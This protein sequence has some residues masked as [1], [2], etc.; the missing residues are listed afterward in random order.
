MGESVK[1]QTIK[2]VFW[3]VL[4]KMSTYLVTFVINVIMA[5]L[6]T[7]A[8]YGIVGI[9]AVFVSFSQLFIDGGFT[10]A[11]IAKSDRDETDYRTV[12]VFNFICSI[13]LYILLFL[14]APIIEQFYG[15]TQL[16]KI[17]RAYCVILV[18]SSLSAVQITQLTI[19]ID[20]KSISKIN[21][22]TGVISGCFGVYLAYSGF[23]V[24]AIV[25]QQLLNAALRVL[26]AIYYS[27]WY[28]IFTFSFQRFKKLF[29]FS[30]NLV[31][32]SLIDRIYTNSFPLFI[33]KFFAPAVLG[34]Y[35]RGVQFGSL[36]SNIMGDILNR[37][38]FP[39]MSNIQ[40]D[41]ASLV[42]LYRKYIKLSS[43]VIFPIMMI[44]VVAAEP[45][46]R[47]LLTDKW[48]GCV[49]FMQI[50]SMAFMLAHIGVINRNLLYV[51]KHS[52]WALRLEIVK[53]IV[54]ISIFLFSTLWGIWGVVVGQWFYDMIAPSL[55][56]YYTKRLI[57]LSLW[58]QIHDYIG[59]W[60]ISVLSAVIPLWMVTKIDNVVLQMTL[61]IISY[62]LIYVIVN[63]VCITEPLRY[64]MQSFKNVKG[65]WVEKK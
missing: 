57:G 33:G 21:I 25:G 1:R 13:T 35:A 59:L 11:L 20:F 14:C 28:P 40:E 64:A 37:V 3:S 32:A 46:V 55:N 2:G 19:K 4:E 18:L 47:M 62:I 38:T 41:N 22:P 5:R 10:T 24:W 44:V 26:L 45:I 61:P 16:G 23:G 63:F 36:P 42:M 43:F 51:K 54:A 7:P 49:R 12:F 8:D 56:A 34:N 52:D 39:L 31:L 17:I 53:K 50:I 29:S 60:I 48:L 15:I 9:I 30:S 27:K 6:L 65:R 58:Q